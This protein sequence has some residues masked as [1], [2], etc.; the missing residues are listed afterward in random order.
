MKNLSSPRLLTITVALAL[1]LAVSAFAAP[2]DGGRCG[3]GERME[4]H[5]EHGLKDMKRL[6]DDL[7]L[8]AAQ[9][10]LWQN[11]ATAGKNSRGEMREQMKQHRQA[12]LATLDKPGADL[13]TAL[14][15]MDELKAEGNKRREAARERW[16]SVYDSLNAEQKEKARLFFKS[17]LERMGH[18]GMPGPRQG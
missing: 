17:K 2:P 12:V 5:M 8:D 16:L 6:H 13:R 9:E 4:Q 7:K 18:F 14:K 10:T 1:G 15:Q 3:P 11:A